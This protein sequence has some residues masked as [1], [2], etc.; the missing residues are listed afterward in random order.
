MQNRDCNIAVITLV[1]VI[2]EVYH[3][4][5]IVDDIGNCRVERC[6]FRKYEALLDIHA[7]L[8]HSCAYAYAE[9]II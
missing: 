6:M 9:T 8:H 2:R 5:R 7:A 4:Y 1:R 3:E